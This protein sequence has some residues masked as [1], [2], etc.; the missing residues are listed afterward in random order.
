M[1]SRH[2]V[3]KKEVLSLELLVAKNVTMFFNPIV[4]RFY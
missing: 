3:D 4:V 1:Y 2:L